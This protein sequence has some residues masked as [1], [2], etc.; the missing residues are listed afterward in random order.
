MADI[1]LPVTGKDTKIVVTVDGAL[2]LVADQVV[3]FDA[4]ARYDEVTTKNLGVSGEK[5]D[6]ELLGWGGTIELK[7]QAAT[8]DEMIDVVNAAL[9]ARVPVLLSI[10]DITTYRSGVVKAYTYPDVKLD[11]KASKR[12]ADAQTVTIGWKT[13]RD[14]IALS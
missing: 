3:G 13:G 1:D 11:F 12:R 4:E 14:R 5:I 7:A 2:K 10:N 8:L 9:I 6:K